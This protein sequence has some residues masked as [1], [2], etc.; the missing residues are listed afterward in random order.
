MGCMADAVQPILRLYCFSKLEVIF[1]TF[2]AE[3][4]FVN[5][6]ILFTRVRVY[7]HRRVRV[8]EFIVIL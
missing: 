5:A 6:L 8:L 4:H 7:Q 2:L 1:C 3:N